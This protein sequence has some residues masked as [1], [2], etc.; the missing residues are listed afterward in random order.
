MAWRKRL[1]TRNEDP[2]EL[3]LIGLVEF[4]GPRATV[5]N[6]LGYIT[7]LYTTTLPDESVVCIRLNVEPSLK[8]EMS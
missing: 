8:V 5:E 3:S 4:E 1:D 7:G 2:I 6:A